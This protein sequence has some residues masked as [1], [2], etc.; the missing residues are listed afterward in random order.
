MGG[1]IVFFSIGPIYLLNFFFKG[2]VE[3]INTKGTKSNLIRK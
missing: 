2:R 1:G 3:E